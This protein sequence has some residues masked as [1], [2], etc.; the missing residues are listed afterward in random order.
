MPDRL[1]QLRR[2]AVAEPEEPVTQF[3]LGREL[4][5]RGLDQEAEQAFRQTLL[6]DPRYTAAYRQLGNSLERLGRPEE[7]AVVYRRG[8][9][10]AATT[11]DLQA[12]KEMQAFLRKLSRDYRIEAD[13][14]PQPPC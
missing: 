12:G 14:T 2:L 1:E 9:G 3:L 13:E 6:L 4:A 10:V 8:V 5:S 11:G 7:A